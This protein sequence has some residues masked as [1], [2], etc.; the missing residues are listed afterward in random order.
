MEKFE[1]AEAKIK[2]I[3]STKK[4]INL[5]GDGWSKKQTQKR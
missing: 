4:C 2:E 5:K 3:L 1:L